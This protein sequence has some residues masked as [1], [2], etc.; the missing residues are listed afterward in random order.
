MVHGHDAPPD[1]GRPWGDEG[2][3]GGDGDALRRPQVR[4]HEHDF[5]QVRVARA[6]GVV[7]EDQ[8]D[9]R[10]VL[11]ESIR[12]HHLGG[13]HVHAD[14]YAADLRVRVSR[15]DA[16]VG[17]GIGQPL[18]VEVRLVCLVELVVLLARQLE[19][20]VDLGALAR[21]SLD[22]GLHTSVVDLLELQQ[23]V[24][25]LTDCGHESPG[26]PVRPRDT[27]GLPMT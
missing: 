27:Y 5:V 12:Q 7:R 26:G 6:L 22:P 23:C 9:S 10:T 3:A 2:I 21:V 18:R 24:S 15:A 1:L 25:S 19:Y 20:L 11:S 13:L 8:I 4:L 17:V 14:K 16:G